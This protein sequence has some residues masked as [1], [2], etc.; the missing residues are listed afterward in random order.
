MLRRNRIFDGNV[1]GVEIINNVIVMLE[2]NKIFN[3]K[4]GGL[5]LVSG[6][7]FK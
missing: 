3:N 2:G 6:V 4:F 7:Y 1:V 5:C